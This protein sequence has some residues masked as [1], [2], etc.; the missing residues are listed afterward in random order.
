MY[1]HEIV[2]AIRGGPGDVVKPAEGVVYPRL[3]AYASLVGVRTPTLQLV[4]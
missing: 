3:N 4:K 1:G 2:Q